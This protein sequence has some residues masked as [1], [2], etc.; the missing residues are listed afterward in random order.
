LFVDEV[1]VWNREDGYALWDKGLKHN[2]EIDNRACQLVFQAANPH[3]FVAGQ[4]QQA[5]Q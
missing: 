1:L 2:F 3:L 4:E 5:D